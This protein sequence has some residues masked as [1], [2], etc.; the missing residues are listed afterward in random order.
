VLRENLDKAKEQFKQVGEMMGCFEK[1]FGPYPFYD[2]GYALVETPYAGMEHQSAIAYGNAYKKGYW[3]RYP[4]EMDFDYIIIHETGHEWWGNSVS[5]NDVA[6]MWIHESFCTY[7]E[8]VYVEC[9]Y[10]YE[11]MLEYLGYQKN[12]INNK[13]PITGIYGLNHEGNGTDMYYKGAWMIHTF[14]TVLNN[15]SLFRSILKEIAQD[16]AYQT[17]DGSEIIDY[18]NRKAKYNYTPFFDQFLKVEDIPVLEYKWSNKELSLRWRAEIKG[19]RMPAV[20]AQNESEKRTLVS[21]SD[22]TT[23]PMS[24]KD[25]KEMKFRDDLM[26][27]LTENVAE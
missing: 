27:F 4:G 13:S 19:F 14:R 3:G 23:V 5:M 18:I 20:W 8:A 12:F 2:D 21:N 24:N 15:D 6:D 22:W 9:K 1:A 26:L 10:G 11:K 17:V 16:F 25:F 7:S